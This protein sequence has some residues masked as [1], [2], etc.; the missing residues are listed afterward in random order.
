MEYLQHGTRNAAQRFWPKVKIGW[1]DACWEWIGQRD[2]YGYGCFRVGSWKHKTLKT[3]HA[4]QVAYIL[5]YGRIPDGLC[6]L[7]RCDNPPCVRPDHL[8]LGTNKDNKQDAIKKRRHAHGMHHPMAK[9]TDDAVREIRR[10]YRPREYTR[11]MLATEYGVC[12]VTISRIV[13]RLRWE[14]LE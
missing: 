12:V 11:T 14:H 2:R 13:R 4:S 7:H 5:E 1:G 10:K 9:L 8:F 3:R 6:V